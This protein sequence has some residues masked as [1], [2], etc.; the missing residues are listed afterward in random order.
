[1]SPSLAPD[2]TGRLDSMR[3]RW[4][5][6]T[7][8]PRRLHQTNGKAPATLCKTTSPGR[9]LPNPN[10]TSQELPSLWRIQLLKSASD[11]YPQVS[12]SK[13]QEPGSSW[14][15]AWTVAAGGGAELRLRER[16]V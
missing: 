6:L 1:M 7:A 10:Q 16:Y 8:V 12:D 2:V 14:L 15:W 11:A 9:F 5:S 4:G 13:L 3:S